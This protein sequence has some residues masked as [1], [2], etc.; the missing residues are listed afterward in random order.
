VCLSLHAMLSPVAI[1]PM[2]GAPV[3]P[4][5]PPPPPDEPD[6]FDLLMAKLQPFASAPASAKF[7][8]KIVERG[9]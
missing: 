6:I 4:A 8:P 7:E 9:K 1:H 5:P 3:Q 2:P